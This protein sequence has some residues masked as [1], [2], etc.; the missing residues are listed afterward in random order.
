MRELSKIDQLI[1]KID[2]VCQKKA[3]PD[4]YHPISYD[5]RKDQCLSTTEKDLSGKLMRVNLC[6][7]VCAQGL[8]FGQA[9]GGHS[10]EVIAQMNQ[11]AEEEEEHFYWCLQRL[12]ELN[13]STSS[14]ASIWFLASCAMGYSVARLGDEISLGFLEETERQVGKH[15]EQ[16][17]R[18]LPAKDSNSRS[19]MEQM[20]LDETQHAEKAKQLGAQNIPKA[21]KALMKTMGT[22]MKMLSY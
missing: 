8:Y 14:L 6:G 20:Y 18:K 15:L 13:T 5:L 11:C 4:S 3:K 7:E 17:I 21:G 22:I 10:K 2:F 12:Q 19:I 16:Y 1:Q 9:L